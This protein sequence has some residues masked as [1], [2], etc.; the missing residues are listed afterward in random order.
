[1]FLSDYNVLAVIA[2]ILLYAYSVIRP[3]CLFASQMEMHIV[4]VSQNTGCHAM[5]PANVLVKDG[6]PQL[7]K[8][9]LSYIL[10]VTARGA[11]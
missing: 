2:A 9:R 4:S 5:L 1:M 6:F 7:R 8:V 11:D 10:R 3:S